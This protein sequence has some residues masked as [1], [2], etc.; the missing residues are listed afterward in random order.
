ML[1]L[2]IVVLLSFFKVFF[3]FNELLLIIVM[4]FFLLFVRLCFFVSFIVSEIDVEVCFI[5]K[6]LCLFLFGLVYLVIL[7]Y[8]VGLR[9][10]V[11]FLVS[12]L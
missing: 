9:N 4:M 12:I 7:L 6:K 11:I 5:V 2:S 8:L 3:L 1:E 10:V